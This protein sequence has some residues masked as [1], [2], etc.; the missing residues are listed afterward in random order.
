ME[1]EIKEANWKLIEKNFMEDLESIIKGEERG[2]YIPVSVRSIVSDIDYFLSGDNQMLKSPMTI[3]L[4]MRSE[5]KS[6]FSEQGVQINFDN[7]QDNEK[8]DKLISDVIN[9]F[10]KNI[11]E[12]YRSEL[13]ENI[14]QTYCSRLKR[15]IREKNSFELEE[16]IEKRDLSNL[17]KNIEEEDWRES[18]KRRGF[19]KRGKEEDCFR[20]DGIIN[21]INS[22][23]E[24]PSLFGNIR[25]KL[26]KAGSN[27]KPSPEGEGRGV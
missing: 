18:E 7:K 24:K 2:R 3:V 10:K 11:E 25:R 21:A 19:L 20:L 15:S 23:K 13:A 26:S 14:I 27:S 22:K 6:Y 9:L 16:Y 12:K 17:E 4:C 5:L 1:G 8:V